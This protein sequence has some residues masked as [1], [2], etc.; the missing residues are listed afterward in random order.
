MKRAESK[1][2]WWG[3]GNVDKNLAAD[4]GWLDEMAIRAGA[5]RGQEFHDDPY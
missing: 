3:L 1:N 5:C 4:Q 2:F